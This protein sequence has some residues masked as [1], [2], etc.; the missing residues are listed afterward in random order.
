MKIEVDLKD[1]QPLVESIVAQVTERVLERVQTTGARKLAI[2]AVDKKRLSLSDKRHGYVLG[3]NGFVT[4]K[5]A[6]A[7]LGVSGSTVA[8][9]LHNGLLRQKKFGPRR[10]SAARICAR[11]LAE[12]ARANEG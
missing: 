7:F 2:G 1:L 12:Y 10:Q 3:A 6:A 9:L 4:K 11:S 8:R 5:D